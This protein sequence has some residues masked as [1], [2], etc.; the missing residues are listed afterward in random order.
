[1]SRIC[2]Q[3]AGGSEGLNHGPFAGKPEK[4]ESA[5]DGLRSAS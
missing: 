1:M 5:R 4:R 3:H 2:K